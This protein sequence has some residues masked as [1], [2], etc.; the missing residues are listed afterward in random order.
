MTVTLWMSVQVVDIEPFV[1]DIYSRQ[2]WSLNAGFGM[3]VVYRMQRHFVLDLHLNRS[4]N[5]LPNWNRIDWAS[6]WLARSNEE[7]YCN[8]RRPFDGDTWMAA[9]VRKLKSFNAI[10]S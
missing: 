7:D 9:S 2:I 4:M 3:K 6:M 1:D 5:Y 8:G 10:F